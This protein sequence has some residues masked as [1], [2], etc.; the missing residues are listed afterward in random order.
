MSLDTTRITTFE[1]PKGPTEACLVVIHSPDPS[2]LGHRFPLGGAE[3]RIGREPDNE[4]VLQDDAAS[5]RHAR[6]RIAG[7]GHRVIDLGSTN[8][9]WVND[10]QV[11]EQALGSGDLLR[12]GSTVL[13]YLV[14]GELEA[15]YHEELRALALRDGL[16]GAA[17]KRQLLEVLEREMGRHRR[18]A[19]PLSLLIVDL[20]RFKA[21]NDALGHLAG[22]EVL[23][24]LVRIVTPALRREDCLARFGGDE[25]ALVLPETALEGA[26]IVAE[27]VRRRVEEGPFTF[28]GLVLPVTASVG[29]A[30]LAP[31]MQNPEDLISAADARLFE[32]K[33]GGR[34]RMVP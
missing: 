13:K 26:R 16:T 23:R 24:N 30:E 32:A 21:V 12:I 10:E 34:N 6:I 31:E 4:V 19:R 28:E 33:R 18:H 5:R 29:I 14:G 2:R 1:R 3:V 8:G 22:D 20:D 11:R 7:G 9:T 15:R 27:K 17:N 25:F